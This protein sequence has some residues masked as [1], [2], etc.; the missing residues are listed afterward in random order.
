MDTFH[1]LSCHRLIPMIFRSR[2]LLDDAAV[3]PCGFVVGMST[4]VRLCVCMLLLV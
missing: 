2:S 4:P 3:F 1:W